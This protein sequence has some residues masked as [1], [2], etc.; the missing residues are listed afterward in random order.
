MF[1]AGSGTS[2]NPMK[3]VRRKYFIDLGAARNL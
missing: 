1:M 2:G 3:N